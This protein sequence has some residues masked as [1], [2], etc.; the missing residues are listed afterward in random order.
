MF[1]QLSKDW[2]MC[3]F[4]SDIFDPHL[5]FIYA[6][7]CEL[8]IKTYGFVTLYFRWPFIGQLFILDIIY[9][10]VGSD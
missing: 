1:C 10:P 2:H 8:S 3:K 7:T 9:S 6:F 4:C 5:F